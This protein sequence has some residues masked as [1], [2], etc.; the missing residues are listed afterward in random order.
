[1]SNNLFGSVIEESVDLYAICYN[2]ELMLPHFINHYRNMGVKN[3]TIFDNQSTDNSQAIIKQHGCNLEVYDS[4]NQIRDD[5]YLQIKNECW[6]NSKSEWVIV[7]D[8]DEFI[9][10]DFD[11]KDYTIINTKGYDMIGEPPSRTGSRQPYV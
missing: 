10:I 1:M 4:N 8:I 2:E 6:K 5:L 9:E 11:I 3:I 7:C